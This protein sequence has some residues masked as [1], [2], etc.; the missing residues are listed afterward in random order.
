MKLPTKPTPKKSEMKDL[1]VLIYGKSK[2][3][4]STF[5]AGADKPLF[6]AT[7]P[8]LN[9][10]EVCQVTISN[11]SDLRMAYAAISNAL[12]DGTFD[13]SNIVIDTIDNA[14]RF[15]SDHVCRELE[16]KHESDLDYGRGY[17]RVT[18]AWHGFLNSM[19]AL[20][21]GVFLIGHSTVREIK[22][23]YGKRDRTLLTIPGGAAGVVY[24]LVD[25]ILLAEQEEYE[26][27]TTGRIVKTKPHDDY[28]AGDRTGMLP[29]TL[30]LDY[31]EFVK[32]FQA[33]V[34]TK[35][36]PKNK[37]TK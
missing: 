23:K 36:K 25:M 13:Y 24:N 34:D 28:E 14:Y 15:C 1:N 8:G 22:T 26:D 12:N 27:G 6:L 5:C 30:P 31:S 9:H 19:A 4:K 11:W 35:Q 16:I 18:Q 29:E 7:E 3:G 20:P 32:A 33:A 2:I 37:E 17:Q 10:L 21:V